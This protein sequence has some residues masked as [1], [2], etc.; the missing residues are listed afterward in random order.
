MSISINKKYLK[1]CGFSLEKVTDMGRHRGA[2]IFKYLIT[3]DY[4]L[5]YTLYYVVAL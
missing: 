5:K 3:G 2:Y 4:A 1:D